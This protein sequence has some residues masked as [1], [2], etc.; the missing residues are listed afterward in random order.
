MRTTLLSCIA[1][2]VT[3]HAVAKPVGDPGRG[4]GLTQRWCATCHQPVGGAAATDMVPTFA[5]IA[6]KAKEDPAYIRAFLN[7]PHA[8]MPPLDLDQQEIA[9]IVAYFDDLSKR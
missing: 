1:L 9:D 4:E 6:G 5:Q 7:H 3:A 8:P 2:L